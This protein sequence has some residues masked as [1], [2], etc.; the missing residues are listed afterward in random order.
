[1]D[2]GTSAKRMLMNEEI[3]LKLGYIGIKNRAQEDINNKVPVEKSLEDERKFFEGHPDYKDLPQEV[4]GTKSLTTKLS[5]ILMLHI[6]RCLP[7]IIKEINMKVE[8]LETRLSELGNALPTN[9]KE[10]VNFL[11]NMITD[12]TTGFRNTISGKYVSGSKV[13]GGGAKIKE[14]MRKVYEDFIA[15]DY[16]CSAE[17]T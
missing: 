7:A 17:Y 3:P 16:K 12:F 4:L 11:M 13:A 1:M 9:S 15:T 10:R 14:D 2:Q 8:A 6:G 5:N